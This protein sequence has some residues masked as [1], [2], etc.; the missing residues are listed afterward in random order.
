VGWFRR[1]GGTWT[2]LPAGEGD[3][4]GPWEAFSARE[5]RRLEKAFRA[6]PV[7]SPSPTPASSSTLAEHPTAGPKAFA[8]EKP[9]PA[10]LNG[11]GVGG[12][13]GG[14]NETGR[15]GGNG[16]AAAAAA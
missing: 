9:H 2:S 12:E 13:V 6:Q 3:G 11:D 4:G 14:G 10:E 5:C 8:A 7:S 16:A 1:S 15:V